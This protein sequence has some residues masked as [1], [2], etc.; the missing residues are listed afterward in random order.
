MLWLV[1]RALTKDR[2]TYWY[3]AGMALACG[4]L[5]KYAMGY[6]VL[7]LWLFLATSPR[8]RGWL[9]C[10]EPYLMLAIWNGRV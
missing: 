7:T 5:S 1:Y 6:V 2:A 10:K 4:L 3:V 8:Y 9:R